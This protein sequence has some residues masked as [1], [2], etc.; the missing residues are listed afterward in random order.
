MA[1][2]AGYSLNGQSVP[3][4]DFDWVV[5]DA[6][7]QIQ[8]AIGDAA[9]NQFAAMRAADGHPSPFNLKVIEIGNEGII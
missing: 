7:N 5:Q 6:V 8:Y 9:F 2:Y 1:V 3:E 4:N